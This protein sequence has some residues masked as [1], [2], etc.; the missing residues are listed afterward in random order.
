M[1]TSQAPAGTIPPQLVSLLDR[2][3]KSR[4]NPTLHDCAVAGIF[5]NFYSQHD[6]RRDRRA[7]DRTDRSDRKM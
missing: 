3:G 2:L 5:A 6:N 1:N 7:S 4:G